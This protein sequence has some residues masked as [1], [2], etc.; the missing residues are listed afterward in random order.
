MRREQKTLIP[1]G[2]H[3]HKT[4]ATGFD[5]ESNQIE[6]ADGKKISYDYLVMATGI[7]I[8]FNEIKGLKDAFNNDEQVVSMYSH[9]QVQR[10]YPAIQ[11]FK[12]GNAIFTFPKVPIKCPGAP[13]KIMYLAED[14]FR[15][16]TYYLSMES[17]SF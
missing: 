7:E 11:R 16:V 5:P 15:I 3:W 17:A 12:G 9:E 4:K 8:N 2:V 14:Y 1:A 6:L 10:V 13:Q